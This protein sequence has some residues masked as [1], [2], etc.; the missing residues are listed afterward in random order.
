VSVFAAA[1]ARESKAR[2][3]CCNGKKKKKNIASLCVGLLLLTDGNRGFFLS[4]HCCI[5]KEK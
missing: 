5:K 1:E 3:C 2:A 4:Q